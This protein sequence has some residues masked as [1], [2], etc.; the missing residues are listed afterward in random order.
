MKYLH[1]L[2]SEPDN[3]SRLLIQGLSGDGT[4]KEVRLYEGT[5]DYAHL[6]DDIFASDRVISWWAS[7]STPGAS[8]K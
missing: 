5:V 8:T 2:R 7:R 1:I 4:G 3:V 6:L